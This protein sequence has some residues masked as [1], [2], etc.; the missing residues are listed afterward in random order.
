MTI[1]LEQ[2]FYG[3]GERGYGVLG[4][5]PDG[6]PFAARVE[7]LCGAVG[8]PGADYGGEPFLLSVPEGDRV[9][10]ICGRRGAP[11]SMGRET[12]FFHALVAAKEDLVA[13]Q[14]D[15]F[16]LFA[17]GAFKAKMPAGT[18]EPLR[19]D[20]KPGRDG[21]TSRPPDG[22]AVDVSLPCFIRVPSPAPDI[23]RAFVG[24]RANDL[25]WATFAFQPMSGFDM[26][27]LPPRIAAPH[28]ANECDADGKLVR[29]A[30][31]SDSRA[32]PARSARAPYHD[33]AP[34]QPLYSSKPST[35]LKISLFANLALVVVCAALFAAREPVPVP[36]EPQ[37]PPV[38]MDVVPKADYDSVV[39]A[40]RNARTERDEAV[41]KAKS[42]QEAANASR[43]ALESIVGQAKSIPANWD[44][45]RGF[46]GIKTWKEASSESEEGKAYKAL[47]GI[48]KLINT[49]TNQTTG[50]TEQ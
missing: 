18:I 7:A 39:S 23:V 43:S 17:Q 32:A 21:S 9:L 36:P 42:E 27:V 38:D 13:A 25:A 46:A 29:A 50:N 26:Q 1:N 47:Q 24:D 48:V 33:G 6:A 4:A 14:A 40:L 37:R 45:L 28:F 11:D 49:I 19:I 12:L 3:R 20:C 44:G 8:T 5:S 35:M 2:F 31:T 16:S 34:K 15:A 41:R 30:E 10:M 22:H